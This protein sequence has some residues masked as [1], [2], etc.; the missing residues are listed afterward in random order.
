MC[1]IL[2]RLNLGEIMKVII[3]AAGYATRLS[4]ITHDKIAK[5]MLPISAEGKKQPILFFIL[6]KLYN[7]E[8][9]Y[10]GLVENI[11]I[12]SNN[13]YFDSIKNSVTDYTESKGYDQIETHIWKDGTYSV[14]QSGGANLNLCRVNCWQ[15]Q[16]NDDV[17]IIA[18]DNYFDLDLASVVKLYVNKKLNG[19][20]PTV[21]VS[22]Q[23]PREKREFV[24]KNFGVLDV[25]EDGRVRRIIEKP[26]K[27]GIKVD[28][29]LV[30][31]AVYMMHRRNLNL[32][33]KYMDENV[34]NPKKRDSLG[35]FIGYL[36]EN[37]PTFNYSCNGRFVDIG[38]PE[39]YFEIAD[40][41]TWDKSSAI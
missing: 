39:D 19:E 12:V 35:Y 31:M 6:D 21:L 23:F 20:V 34:D 14:E 40:S 38:S 5:T 32:I 9:S 11:T 17:L 4:E 25:M 16:L 8:A 30:C 27:N 41:E 15:D 7:L 1:D 18:G 10:P 36:I 33:D 22:K 2:A 29:D 13:R 3:L 37:T 28:S 26:G 24:H